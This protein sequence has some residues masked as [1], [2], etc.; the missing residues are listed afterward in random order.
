MA[1][2]RL[3]EGVNAMQENPDRR[4]ERRQRRHRLGD[5]GG[6]GL[7]V[8]QGV[9]G[10]SQDVVSTPI[11]SLPAAESGRKLCLPDDERE[12]LRQALPIL[13]KWFEPPT[14]PTS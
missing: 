2:A 13:K 5:I 3:L 9:C 12:N 8:L 4:Q 11:C 14:G 1:V 6:C 10:V 7:K